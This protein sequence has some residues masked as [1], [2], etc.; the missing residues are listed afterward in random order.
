ML[1]V[2][3]VLAHARAQAERSGQTPLMLLDEAMAQWSF[4]EAS[5]SCRSLANGS[6]DL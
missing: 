4:A 1:L 5:L 3:I 6:M 2:A